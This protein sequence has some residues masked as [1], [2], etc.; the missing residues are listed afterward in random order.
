MPRS[1]GRNE[2]VASLIQRAAADIIRLG[3]KDPRVR[4]ASVS[5]VRVSPDLRNARI[6]I[7]FLNADAAQVA[8]AM[9]G[10]NSAKGFVRSAIAA[11]LTLRY[12]P[13]ITFE[14]DDLI[15]KSM[16]LDALIRK[17]LGP[18]EP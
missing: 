8:S 5:E 10:L 16:A 14:H 9:E 1:H 13:D 17:G 15:E 2:R 6:Y 7:S 4:G 11:Q 12:M 3:I 18:E